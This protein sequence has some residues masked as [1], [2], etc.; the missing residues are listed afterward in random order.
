MPR[1]HLLQPC[2]ALASRLWHPAW[3][4]NT[5][6]ASLKVVVSGRPLCCGVQGRAQVWHGG[7]GPV[8]GVHFHLGAAWTAPS[9]P[10]TE[11]RVGEASS[12]TE[13]PDDSDSHLAWQ[14]EDFQETAMASSLES[15]MRTLQN[16]FALSRQDARHVLS[17][18]CS[19][20]ITEWSILQNLHNLHECGIQGQQ[21]YR[22]PWILTLKSDILCKKLVKIKE[23]GLF[24]E[25]SEGLGFCYLPLE[26]MTTYQKFFRNEAHD[27]PNHPNRIYYLAERIQVP[28]E[29]FTERIGKPHRTLSMTI[30][31]L[32]SMIDM[33]HQFGLSPVD[34]VS[35]LWVFGYSED[36]ARLRLQRAVE[37]GCTELKPWMFCERYQCGKELLGEHESLF[38]YLSERLDCDPSLLERVFQSNMVMKKVHIS[39]F[40][41]VLDLLFEEG[42]T[43]RDIRSCMRVFQYSEK[44]TAAR[45]NELK[46]LGFFPFPLIL[47]CRTPGQ[48]NEILSQHKKR[49]N[50]QT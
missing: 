37:L 35:D 29:L 43:A 12:D 40:S 8:S 7:C 38:S 49:N 31:R 15:A 9:T 2:L 36:K 47:L 39:K 20:A 21:I 10:E 34:I 1:M 50:W 45:I 33:F 6:P 16:I 3:H 22:L 30:R 32:D 41:K 13:P 28:V 46:Q 14:T 17:S 26:R 23:P 42:I 5:L 11:D 18:C 24:Q 27:F 4:P 48:F 25:H 44:R 19:P